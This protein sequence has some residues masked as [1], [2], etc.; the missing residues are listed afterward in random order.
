MG[1]WQEAEDRLGY[2][3]SSCEDQ[4]YPEFDVP[5]KKT[6]SNEPDHE[7]DHKP[8][9]IPHDESSHLRTAGFPE[10][11]QAGREGPRVEKA[12]RVDGTSEAADRRAGEPRPA[13]E[14]ERAR[15]D[16][17]HGFG[18]VAAAQPLCSV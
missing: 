1:A 16:G 15:E 2:A 3:F 11:V 5:I 4:T 17:G 14:A 12:G 8:G 18:F 10:D 13:G 9:S 7:S 6:G